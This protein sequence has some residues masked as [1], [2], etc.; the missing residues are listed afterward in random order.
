MLNLL[1]WVI[2]LLFPLP[3]YIISL[4]QSSMYKVRVGSLNINDG[5]DRQKRAVISELV[6]QRRL[7]I[8]FLQ[9]THS[10]KDNEIDLDLWWKGQYVLT[11]GTNF[12]AGVAILFSSGLDVNVISTTKIVTGRT[13]VVR[14]EIQDISFCFINIYAPNH[15][16][17][18]SISLGK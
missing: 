12:S 9:E 6:Q 7:D 8:V 18:R 2:F 10:D 5:R 13:L 11:H 3:V 17:D 14:E 1:R 16:S 4:S 15:R